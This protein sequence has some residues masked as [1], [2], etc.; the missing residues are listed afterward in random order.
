[1]ADDSA[2]L[3]DQEKIKALE[4][5]VAALE[6]RIVLLEVRWPTAQ[7]WYPYNPQPYMPYMQYGPVWGGQWH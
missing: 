1:M 6:A 2:A 7:P 3:T 5:K 4:S